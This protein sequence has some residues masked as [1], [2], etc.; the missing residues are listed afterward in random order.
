MPRPK[1]SEPADGGRRGGTH[2]AVVATLW[3]YVGTP[4]LAASHWPSD[5]LSS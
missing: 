4:S 5:R 1:P 2:P 3:V